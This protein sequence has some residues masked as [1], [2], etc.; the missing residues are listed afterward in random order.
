MLQ[1]W[2]N[3][4]PFC[5]PV[6][7]ATKQKHWIQTSMEPNEH[8]IWAGFFLCYKCPPITNAVNIFNSDINRGHSFNIFD[9][10][11]LWEVGAFVHGTS[12]GRGL[13]NNMYIAFR[14]GYSKDPHDVTLSWGQSPLLSPR[15]R[16]GGSSSSSTD[17]Y[18]CAEISPVIDMPG[19]CRIPSCTCA[20]RLMQQHVHDENYHANEALHWFYTFFLHQHQLAS[21]LHDAIQLP[22]AIQGN[23]TP[24]ALRAVLQA[25]LFSSSM[26]H[27]VQIQDMLH[28]W[29]I[30]PIIFYVCSAL[31]TPMGYHFYYFTRLGLHT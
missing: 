15:Q 6:F 10:F 12:P 26:H 25:L 19:S 16:G 22:S 5:E 7:Y 18:A 8:D 31:T 20:A 1:I 28:R 21:L 24:T 3:K 30:I 11:P 23:N 27:W 29:M 14:V 17:A 4:N 2:Q 13:Q 9:C